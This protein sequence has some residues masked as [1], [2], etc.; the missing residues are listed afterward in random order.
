MVRGTMTQWSWLWKKIEEQQC[1]E[2][3][4]GLAIESEFSVLL[5]RRPK[6]A[7]LGHYYDIPS[8]FVDRTRSVEENISHLLRQTVSIEDAPLMLD[9]LSAAM[10]QWQGKRVFQVNWLVRIQP[11]TKLQVQ[12]YEN[13]QWVGVDRWLYYP[14]VPNI[15]AAI[16]AVWFGCPYAP[17]IAQAIVADA[18]TQQRNSI[19]VHLLVR[20]FK[21]LKILLLEHKGMWHI[22]GFSLNS[23]EV[24]T[25]EVR[26]K[27]AMRRLCGFHEMGINSLLGFH[28]R[29]VDGKKH[30]DIAWVGDVTVNAQPKLVH[31]SDYCWVNPS[32]IT[33]LSV[34]PIAQQMIHKFFERYRWDKIDADTGEV[35]KEM[36][37]TVD[38]RRPIMG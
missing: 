19:R 30:R 31:Y 18:K 38:V 14:L 4:F 3:A 9:F 2:I 13:P 28:D 32:E 37:A 6:E 22:P 5:L 7:V 24:D 21:G 10:Y 23:E 11:G 29:L 25:L 35:E 1:D 33:G 8:G 12:W 36:A 27:A 34:A 17:R 26:F 15:R 20:R 16:V